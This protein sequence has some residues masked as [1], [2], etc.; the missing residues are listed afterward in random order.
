MER[1]PASP[2]T[3]RGVME[4]SSRLD[5]PTG[6]AAE[7]DVPTRRG[8]G[9]AVLLVLTAV[10]VFAAVGGIATAVSSRGPVTDLPPP[11]L[12]GSAGYRFI[13]LDA[14]TGLPSR[15]DPCGE[16]AY[17]VN[18]V[19]APA[20]AVE[21]VQ[22]AFRRAELA[23]GIRFVFEGE[24]DEVPERG[25]AP[26]QP[27][28]YGERWAPILV[29]W[30]PMASGDPVHGA[31]VG[32][33]AHSP[34]VSSRSQDV[35]TTGTIALDRDARSV[36]SGF[37]SGRRWGNV[38]LHELGHVLGLDHADDPGEVM[39]ATVDHGAGEWGPGDLAGLDYLGRPAGCLRSPGPKDVDVME[40]TVP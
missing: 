20:G 9:R 37:G 34:L 39:A 22:E 36:H 6:G 11:V 8:P 24:V 23:T 33:G 14:E 7:P 10:L 31:V 1:A 30:V 15:F 5:V 3:Y 13:H 17:V 26:Y 27:E 19:D 2:R 38:V 25:R 16:V 21:D 40:Q 29:G 35:V 18:P 28:V 32:W 4:W 12:D